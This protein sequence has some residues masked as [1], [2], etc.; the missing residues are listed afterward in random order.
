MI[1]YPD[2]KKER[3]VEKIFG[4]EVEDSYR[5]MEDDSNKNLG[6]WIDEQNELT[7][8]YLSN[9]EG[10]SKIKD[11][12]TTLYNYSKYEI[13]KV[14]GENIIFAYNDGLQNQS[15]YYI[16]EGINGTPKVLIDPNTLSNDGTVAVHLN[17]H[18][19]DNRYITYLQS[20]AGS[21][22]HE[23]RVIDLNTLDILDDI[24]EWVKYT[25]VSWQKDGFYYSAFDA[26]KTDKILS[27]KNSDM[28]VFYHTLGQS[29]SEDREVYA[30]KENPLRYHSL[31]T[32]EDEKSLILSSSEGTYGSEIKLLSEATNESFKTVFSGF[33]S[34]K[35]YISSKDEFAYFISDENAKNRKIVRLNT[36]TF[37]KETIIEEDKLTLDD[38]YM[39]KDKLILIYLNNV[40]SIVKIHNLDGEYENELELL[41]VGTAFQFT[42][43]EAYNEIFYGFTSFIQPDVF[44]TF[45]L[46]NLQSK[47]FKTSEV[48]Y[49]T[50]EYI[51]EQIFSR[52]KDGTM[53]PSF[54]TYKKDTE[55][56]GKCPTLLYA[57]GGFS[58]TLT[59]S[60]K[61][62]IIYLLERG[63]IFVV[64]N[65]RGGSEYGE[66][67]H[68]AGMLLNKQNVYDDFISV[69]EFLIE[70]KYTS[71]DH[72]AISGGSNGGLLIGAV[73]NQRPD[74]FSVALPSVGVMDM[75]RYH[76]FTIGWGWVVE[77][78]NP[79][80][81]IHFNNII[82][83]SPL[84]NIEAKDY[85]ATM[86]FTA[87]HDD[88]VVPAHSF[89]YISRLQEKNTSNKP[90]LIRIDKKSGHGAGKSTEKLIDEATDKFTFLFN[91]IK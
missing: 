91:N 2:S 16:Q 34:S 75:L 26:P 46:E 63:G 33:S 86:V 79:E 42:S 11:R 81:E 6:V 44:Y 39:V 48:S 52:S 49:D 41:S 62:P 1:K 61:P 12:L 59:P 20:S 74:M 68:K 29:Q 17:G 71:K 27:E 51:T 31:F 9:I 66:E 67:W 35:S 73:V 18:S 64:A 15:V 5:W 78:G 13:V 14:V 10:R 23:I 54:V 3:I 65:I 32:T 76:K 87:D 60:F 80:E 7:H 70:K 30:D 53:V 22:W 72:L 24:L 57:Y 69:I 4:K 8:S 25:V 82:K 45:N 36:F 83:Y 50:S 85:P 77:Y 19:K 89:K 56:N 88:R 37:K 84:H 55:L 40:K 90:M 47:A 21:D 58:I 43:S 38:V 28:K